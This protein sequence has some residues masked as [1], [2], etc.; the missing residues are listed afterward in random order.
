MK[1]Y[2]MEESGQYTIRM[3]IQAESKE[4]AL[5]KFENILNDEIPRYLNL[6]SIDEEI[7]EFDW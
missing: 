2:L 6:E 3:S 5:E 4:E 7:E 1:N